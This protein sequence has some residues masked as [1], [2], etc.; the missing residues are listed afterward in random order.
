MSSMGEMHCGKHR[1]HGSEQ[2]NHSRHR[3]QEMM[4]CNDSCRTTGLIL[5]LVLGPQAT[6][7][8]FF[9]LLNI[10]RLCQEMESFENS[11]TGLNSTI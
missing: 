8:Y 7:A 11:K 3:S 6:V 5:F 9:L 1:R 4:D 2:L 10:A